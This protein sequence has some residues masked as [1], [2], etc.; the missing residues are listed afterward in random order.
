MGCIAKK[1]AVFAF[2][3]RMWSVSIIFDKKGEEYV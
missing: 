3:E 2:F 1:V